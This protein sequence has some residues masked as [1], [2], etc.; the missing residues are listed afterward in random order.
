ME[1]RNPEAPQP[2]MTDNYVMWDFFRRFQ[3][4][5]KNTSAHLAVQNTLKKSR[6]NGLTFSLLNIRHPQKSFLSRLA[7]G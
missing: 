6:L 4:C 2:R 7:I 3:K 1:I 5:G